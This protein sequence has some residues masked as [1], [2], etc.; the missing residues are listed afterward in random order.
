MKLR[1][2]ALG[3]LLVACAMDTVPKGLQATPA[4]DGPVVV[5]DLLRRPLPEIP[6][7][8]DVA[9]F[10]DPT[11]RTG[12]RINVSMV[13]PTDL[14]EDARSGFAEMEGWGTFA[15]ISVSFTRGKGIPEGQ[16]A[17]DLEDVRARMQ[18]DGYDT[19]NDPVYVIDLAT[20]VPALL[21]A[22]GGSFPRTIRDLGNYYPN[23]PRRNEQNFQL[24]TAEE[25]AG[26]TQS[27][28]TPALD[29]DFDGVLDHPNTLASLER[30][31]TCSATSSPCGGHV[32][33]VDDLLDFYERET[34]TLLLRPVL[35][36][37][38]KTEYAVV[39]TDR[40]RDTLGRPVRSPFPVVYHPSQE[41]S[42]E[43]LRD[44]LS[45]AG[46][47]NYYG[48]IAGSGLSH[49]AFAWTFTTAPQAEDLRLL[50]DG[51]FGKGPFARLATEY[52]PTM[53]AFRA[54]GLVTDQTLAGQ[55]AGWQD[56]PTCQTAKTHP[57]T[58]RIDDIKDTFAQV[59]QRV[60]SV[61]QGQL[62]AL[63]ASL[64]SVDHIV[65]GSYPLAYLVGP[66]PA[67][68]NPTDRFEVNY[69]TGE[70]RFSTDMGHFWITVPKSQPSKGLTEPF[71]TVVWGHGTTL[72]AA[73]IIIRAGYFAKQGL[74]MFGFDGPGHGLA[75]DTGTKVLM[76]G[77]LYNTCLEPW[78]TALESGRAHDL[79]GDGVPDPGG[80]LWTAH[81]FHSRDNIRQTV[82]DGI[83]ASRVLRTFDGRVGD[84]DYNDDG[85]LDVLGDFDGDGTPD[86]GGSTPIYSSG[87]SYGG[88]FT[89]I[90][91]A[92]DPNV[93]A[94][95]SISGGGGLI[96]IASRSYGVVDSVLEQIITPLVVAVPA[97]SRPHDGNSSGSATL[98][99]SDQMSVRLVVNDLT[100]SREIEI[101]CLTKQELSAGMTVFVRNAR[102]DEKRC[103]R[104]LPDGSFRVPIPATQGDDLQIQLFDQPDA[105]DSY[106]TCNVLPGAP[107]GRAITTFE[108]RAAAYRSVGDSTATCDAPG[109]CQQYRDTFYPVGSQLVA[110]Q[111]G[112]GLLRQSP[113]VR[114]LL[115]LTQA[116]VD[117]AD[118]I[119]Y[120][121]YYMLAPNPGPDGTPQGPK[122]FLTSNTVADGFVV[123][124]S[125]HSFARASGALPFLPPSA[126][127]RMPEYADWVTPPKIYQEL[128]DRTPNDA[129]SDAYV[130]E[131]VARL[132]R[133]PAGPSCAPNYRANSACTSPAPKVD[134]TVCAETVFDPDWHAEGRDLYA[135]Q[136]FP[137]PLRLARR[138]DT[139]VTDESSL[140]QAWSPRLL[141]APFTPD[142]GWVPD[143]TPVVGL[144]DAYIS[145]LGEHVWTVSDPCKAWD[146]AV[147]YDHVLGRFLAS[148]G[149]D[150]YYLSHPT[151]HGCLEDQS[152]A[153]LQ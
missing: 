24:E 21:D 143:G 53:S 132:Q 117:P 35:P 102:N 141:G 90:H 94:G 33:G 7:P 38:E 121:R 60:F 54:A 123:V 93:T 66:D 150:L 107:A 17:I 51:L 140:L 1:V 44:V 37:E 63:L 116:A 20:G 100:R 79:D 56:N 48:D 77:L 40:L 105:V 114:R 119:N 133:E 72:N 120:A 39:L 49:V 6:A 118:P 76:R 125:G 124:G 25:G 126:L 13:A 42:I 11:S 104:T 99:A 74:A 16:A 134:P 92:M 108:Q 14:E 135:A 146:D 87:D 81:I 136:H 148:S 153:F 46:R 10:A 64:D 18:R 47:S 98:C 113:D 62:D 103:A 27:D 97:S 57:Y 65:I 52:P 95:G 82:L 101:A 68:E 137:V 4:G 129:L 139:R 138:A 9:T 12:R 75:L 147:Y 32:H 151:T 23:D 142:G 152:C 3:G 67:H 122:G 2:L 30:A 61:D 19:T 111:S 55:P 71:P 22:N 15:P 131:G 112:L 109:G 50:R 85:V 73:E 45:D 86:L 106:K 58:V 127:P 34:D 110:P 28:Y 78:A 26:L 70:G 130:L 43:K 88:I 128:G 31:T 96:D 80:L 83:Q 145:P 36:L 69:R 144:M 89:M 115:Q 29:T 8:N 91:T 5:F 41:T 149:S 84:Q 59:I